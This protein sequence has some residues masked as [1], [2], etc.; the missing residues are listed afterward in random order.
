MKPGLAVFVVALVLVVLALDW[1]MVVPRWVSVA[2]VVGNVVLA[3]AVFGTR[4]MRSRQRDA[5][6]QQD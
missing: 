2:V 3:G 4:A 6:R 5:E 1:L